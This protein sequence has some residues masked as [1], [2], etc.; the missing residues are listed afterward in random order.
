MFGYR[1][2]IVDVDPYFQGTE[3][4]YQTVA[5]SRPPKDQPWYHVLVDEADHT[6]YVAERNLEPD[7]EKSVIN[8]PL[9]NLIF[10]KFEDG[11]Y[12][13]NRLNN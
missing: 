12:V 1:G 9:V 4:W 5:K 7:N 11:A 3:E 6:T 8:H 2:V 10:Q 13:I